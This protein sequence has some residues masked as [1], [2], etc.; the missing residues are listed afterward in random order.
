MIVCVC[1]A[2]TEQ[3]L[4]EVAGSDARAPEA[5][6]VK[7]GCEPQCGCCLDYAQEILDEE[8]AKRP[9]LRIVA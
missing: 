5:A 6:Y 2:I 4:R 9:Q 1:N 7:L 3:E 8:L